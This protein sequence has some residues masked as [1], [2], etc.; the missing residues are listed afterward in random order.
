[1]ERARR[2]HRC[3]MQ[4][5]RHIGRYGIIP[6]MKARDR[7]AA[8]TEMLS[9]LLPKGSRAFKRVLGT[10]CRADVMKCSAVGRSVT[11]SHAVA[12]ELP[13]LKI[14]FGRSKAGIPW[15]APDGR[16]VNFLWLLVH[17]EQEHERYLQALSQVVRLCRDEENREK[18]MEAETQ[19]EIRQI[20]VRHGDAPC[21]DAQF[22]SSE[23]AICR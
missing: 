19:K 21:E 2:V 5:H 3:A 12:K 8:L 13:S 15:D 11:V 7:W 10:L 16:T 1:M 9:R 4:L 6:D 14:V 18:L 22:P 20:L 17:P 23:D